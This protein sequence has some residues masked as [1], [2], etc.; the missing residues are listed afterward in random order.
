M[1]KKYLM[2]AVAVLALGLTAASCSKDLD[3]SKSDIVGNA[4]TALGVK[5]AP[6]HDWIMAASTN[7][8]V[9]VNLDY[10]AEYTVYIFADEPLTSNA[11]YIG[12]ATL[13]SGE[14]VNITVARPSGAGMLYAAC[15]DKDNHAIYK[16]FA[17]R[18]S[19]TSVAFGESATTTKGLRRATSTG[20]RWSVTPLNMPDLSAYTTGNLI[21][22]QEEI[23]GNGA[24]LPINQADGREAHLKIT[25]SY[26]GSIAR[27]QSYANQSVYVTGTWT[28]PEDQR[29]TGN[30]AIV[31]GNGG[32]IIVPSGCTLSTNANNEAGTTG[33][34]Y[35]MPGGS[36]EGD[37]QLQFSNGTQ[38]YSYNAGNITVSNININGGV[39]YNAGTIGIPEGA[40]WRTAASSTALE[41]PAGTPD[42]P[43]KFINLGKAVFTSVSGA[44]ISFENACNMRVTGDLAIGN[45]SKMDNGSYI[46]CGTLHLNGSNNGGIVL[47]MGNAAYMN[48]LGGFSTNNFGVWGPAGSGYTS[49]AIFK[50]NDCTYVN[51][52]EGKDG[53]TYMLD[54]VE[55]IL[56]ENWT[57]TDALG[58]A[59]ADIIAQ[60][61]GILQPQHP[62]YRQAQLFYQYFNGQECYGIN[63]NNWEWHDGSSRKVSEGYWDAVN[64][65]YVQEVWETIPGGNYLKDNVSLYASDV[66]ESRATC[67]YGTSPSY[68]V[69]VDDSENCGVNIDKGEN[70]KPTPQVYTYAFEDTFM[71]DY[72]MN[73]VVLQVWEEYGTLKIKLCATGASKD[74][75][76]YYNNSPLFQGAEVHQLFGAAA[77]KFV[78]TG[79]SGAGD[80]FTTVASA[81]WPVSEMSKPSGFDYATAGF[82]IRWGNLTRDESIW[83]TTRSD[84]PIGTAPYAVCIPDK[85]A[86]PTEW[87]KVSEA[88]PGNSTYPSF[89]DY[90]GDPSK[91]TW[92]KAPDVSKTISPE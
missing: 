25:G 50:I 53:T 6:D 24:G 8:N 51:T 3:I 92:Y 79:A 78:N 71:G 49:N 32:K 54:H 60:G 80:K 7:V 21:E 52:T 70:R 74:L 23:N 5:I 67:I 82:N 84:S 1:K 17:V 46:E 48:C 81:N 11:D 20:N 22:M 85:W 15:Y 42:A 13:V 28:V 33:M 27:I 73:D 37:G 56:P 64:Q 91:S 18:T 76:V 58:G 41:G 90:A 16:S 68:S 72:D 88:Y 86:W 9:S 35:V 75:Y 62:G 12:S 19:G 30:S 57:T 4:E 2:N 34:I 69:S 47:Y 36:I 83:L 40:N 63:P 87:T 39:L 61:G 31:V 43:S 38:T 26:S 59:G 66:D 10:G 89:A 14:S 77:G 45:S 44:G 29:C 65:I 55:L